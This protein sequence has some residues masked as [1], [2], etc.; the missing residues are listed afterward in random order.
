MVDQRNA[1]AVP[2]A[3]A[4]IYD[5][6]AGTWSATGSLITARVSQTATLLQNG[7]VLV[8]GGQ[9]NGSGYLSSSELFW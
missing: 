3:S 4:E 7:V 8:T 5:P 6:I 2:L 9:G 1:S